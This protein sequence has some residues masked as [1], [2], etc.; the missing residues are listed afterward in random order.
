MTK[1]AAQDPTISAELER[2]V[3]QGAT[4][5]LSR[6]EDGPNRGAEMLVWENGQALGSLGPPR[7][8]QK[9]ALYAEG[10]MARAGSERRR[11]DTPEGAVLLL[12]TI[13]P[14]RP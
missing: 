9:V 8:N 11:F 6:I 1:P 12:T 14:E 13:Y 10:L 2:A 7:L 5:A 3:A 4:V